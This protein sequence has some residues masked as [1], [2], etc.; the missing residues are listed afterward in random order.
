[1]VRERSVSSQEAML[2][3]Y[4]SP[5]AKLNGRVDVVAYDP[6][7]PGL[8]EREAARIRAVLG[9]VVVALEHVGS[10]S[11]PGLAAKPIVDVL[12]VVADSGDESTYVPALEA[13]GYVLRV[14]EPEWHEHRM[15]KGPD[16]DVN[17]HV[18]TVGSPEITRMLTFRDW[19]RAHEEDRAL[20]ESV[21]SGL[22]ARDWTYVQDY[23]DA[24]NDVVDE[25]LSRAAPDGP[26]RD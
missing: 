13:A 5:P 25:I 12:L 3:A 14:R 17:L 26:R 1:M 24:K 10:T 8:F 18:H 19:L 20:Y 6:V 9:P 4:V 15:F 21:K 11:V 16:T 22:A 23:A 2:A 7:W